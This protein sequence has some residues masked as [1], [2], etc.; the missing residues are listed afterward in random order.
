MK[1]V[2]ISGLAGSGK[3]TVADML[4]DG[5][6]TRF[7]K[8]ALADPMKRF[9]QEIFRFTDDQLWGPSDKRN[10]PDKRYVHMKKGALGSTVTTWNNQQDTYNTKPSPEEDIY[11]TPRHALQRLGTEWGRDCYEN[12]WVDYALRVSEK[13][14]QPSGTTYGYNPYFGIVQVP[15]SLS[16][17]ADVRQRGVVISDIRFENEMRA[18]RAAGGKIWRVVRPQ[19]GLEGVS[20]EHR[21]ERAQENIDDSDFDAVLVNN[22]TLA[23]L[24][25]KVLDTLEAR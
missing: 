9:A 20:G 15:S 22:G 1:I 12:V 5:P 11:L 4:V 17:D 7:H 13:L 21:S 10:E 19:S 25:Q 8:V 3:D 6:K 24:A 23:D 2:G 18:I 14:L 16:R